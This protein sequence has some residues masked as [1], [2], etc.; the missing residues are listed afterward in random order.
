MLPFE[1][2]LT[3][4]LAQVEALLD[5]FAHFGVELGLER[6]QTLLAALGN[7]ERRVAVLHIAGSN[8]KGSVCAYLSSVLEVA[9][10]RVGRYISPHLVDWCERMSVNGV[11]ID[12]A[13]LLKLL[14]QVVEAIDPQKPSP[15]QFEVF[16]A[17]AW[18]YFAQQQVDVAVMEVGLGGRL[19]ATNVI[20][21]PLV[22][23]ITS[24]SLE[25]WQRLGPTLADIAREKAGILKP[26]CPAVLAPL[27]PETAAVIFDRL[28]ALN[29]PAVF[30][31][32]AID[33][34]NGWAEFRGSSTEE[35]D[36]LKFPLPL[37]GAHQLINSSLAIA[38]LQILRQQGWQISDEA[39]GQ[40]MKQ[41]RWPGRL[42]WTSWRSRTLL[43]DGA[44]NPA[45]A[46][47]LRQY[48]DSSDRITPPI[49][50]II[51]MIG[52]KDHADVLRE[53]LRSNDSLFLVPVPEH[54]PVDLLKLADL[55][56]SICPKLSACEVFADEISALEAT[57]EK[58]AIVLCGSLYL[59]GH[60][61]RQKEISSSSK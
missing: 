55:A 53:L 29:C 43:I 50:W 39:I 51:G 46:I 28:Q 42:Q 59:I 10:Y 47:A 18:L 16:T 4:P 56:R 13:D 23:V 15:T 48:L 37:L 30:P 2:T 40:G 11:A 22:S 20:D 44:H 19:D 14:Q 1:T 60:F 25:H 3:A 24:L 36:S 33:L 38:T 21:R 45:G 61:L 49:Q 31:P 9:G 12:P 58:G 35:A 6:I 26:G 8:G 27:P 52:G 17:A 57:K 7:P 32:P 34:G 5:R 54:T 41:T